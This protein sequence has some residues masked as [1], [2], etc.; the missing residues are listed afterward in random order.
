MSYEAALDAS[1]RG[2]F[3]LAE[4]LLRELDAAAPNQLKVIHDL[5]AA[6]AAQGRFAEAL[7]L[8]ERCHA[9][10]PD[11]E[12]T[13]LSLGILRLANGDFAG[14]WPLYDLRLKFPDYQTEIPPFPAWRGEPIAGKT[15]VVCREQGFG[16][17]IMCARF[18]PILKAMGARVFLVTLPPLVRLF[19]RL[20][21]EVFGYDGA[22]LRLPA[23]PDY[24]THPFSIP[25]WLGSTPQTLP[26]GPY[27]AA[28]VPR[29]LGAIGVTWRGRPNHPRD[30]FRSLPEDLGRRLLAL[31]GAVSLDPAD[32]GA[33]DFQ[34]TAEI[35]AGLDQ[36]IT[37]DTSVAHLA[38]AMGK[39]ASLL[40]PRH[41]LD[42]RW[43]QDRSDSPW[44]P[45]ARLFRQETPGDW[46]TV[47]ETVRTKALAGF[48]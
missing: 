47:V 9:A 19:Q 40:L 8:Y 1:R 22:P 25:R 2:E 17:M 39:P 33:A 30:G 29:R 3:T 43:M 4:R 26:A 44:Y 48:G 5:G 18:A 11:H 36:V 14:G 31:P 38:G 35:V 13:A 24:H 16:D 20:G 6:L 21:V 41:G 42:W 45:T 7:P 34:D 15:I 32:T 12:R 37:V 28:D 27:L 10:R 46:A 23:I